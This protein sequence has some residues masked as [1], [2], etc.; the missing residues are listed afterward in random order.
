MA[1]N[2]FTQEQID[3]L[4]LNPY[5]YSVNES[6]LRYTKEFKEEFWRRLQ[7]G[8]KTRKIL[9]DL[10]YD[11]EMLGKSRMISVYS[12]VKEEA[13][14]KEGFRDFSTRTYNQ[15]PPHSGQY[16]GIPN[17]LAMQR[18]Q[19]DILHMRQE[20]DFLKKVLALNNTEDK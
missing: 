10:G 8:D 13:C 16:E 1:K 14:S 17:N 3:K 11:P 18:M 7:D 15:K 20:L 5:T 6:T 2:K 9:K 12:Q 19:S 4:R